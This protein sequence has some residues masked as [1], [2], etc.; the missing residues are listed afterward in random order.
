MTTARLLLTVAFLPTL[1][2]VSRAE[3]YMSAGW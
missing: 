1:A 2:V 3:N